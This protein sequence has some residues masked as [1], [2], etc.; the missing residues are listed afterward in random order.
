MRRTRDHDQN[1]YLHGTYNAICDV[2]GFK[3]KAVDMLTTWNGLF[4]CK[5][6][7]E[8]RH[9]LDFG[10]TINERNGVDIPRPDHTPRFID[11]P[12]IQEPMPLFETVWNTVY[13]NE[14]TAAYSGGPVYS[15]TV[16]EDDYNIHQNFGGGIWSLFSSGGLP[17]RSRITA[18]VIS[19]LPTTDQMYFFVSEVPAPYIDTVSISSN[20][21]TFEIPANIRFNVTFLPLHAPD[22]GPA[23]TM[24]QSNQ[25]SMVM[26]LIPSMI[27]MF[28]SG[29]SITAQ[30]KVE[31]ALST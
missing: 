29:D 30:L 12:Y 15:V 4:V 1:Q 24:T 19:A 6:D 2:C 20:N 26:G 23:L 25:P 8:T 16:I 10:R 13:L 31:I 9:I 11:V 27:P 22:P 18:T 5:D 3:K 28:A 14:S 17:Y 21:K 7:F